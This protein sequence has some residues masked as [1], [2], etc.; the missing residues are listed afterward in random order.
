[1]GGRSNAFE[2]VSALV[3]VQLLATAIYVAVTGFRNRVLDG[4]LVVEFA[5]LLV[6]MLAVIDALV[7]DVIPDII[8]VLR[9]FT[10]TTSADTVGKEKEN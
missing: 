7:M 9:G 1:M 10:D 4:V 3:S 5:I 6:V 2:V 8:S